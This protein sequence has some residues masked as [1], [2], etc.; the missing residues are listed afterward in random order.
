MNKR[1]FFIALLKE[2]KNTNITY[3]RLAE[4]LNINVHSLYTWIQK[5]NISEKR[6]AYLLR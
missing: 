5:G 2:M 1:D 3:K 4:K 6:A